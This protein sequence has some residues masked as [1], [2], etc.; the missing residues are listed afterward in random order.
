MAPV[1]VVEGGNIFGSVRGNILAALVAFL[2]RQHA[3]LAM[4]EALAS[5]RGAFG[6]PG[7][8]GGLGCMWLGVMRREGA[9]EGFQNPA[10]LA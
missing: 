9:F 5:A 4:L 8:S 10:S 6:H 3:P 2:G 7:T 1:W